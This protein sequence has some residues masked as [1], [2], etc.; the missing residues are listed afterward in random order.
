MLRAALEDTLAALAARFG[1]DDQSQW[2]MPALLESYRDLG[3]IGPVFGPTLMEREN[4]GSFNLVAEL[5]QAVRGEIIVP[6]GE[7]G[8]FTGADVG[9]EPPHLRDQLPVYEAFQYRRQPF[10]EADLEAP[11]T[12]ETIPVMRRR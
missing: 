1:T 8:T 11:L 2:Q 5:G 4:R 12:M 9:H 7:S 10:A 3:A 6:P